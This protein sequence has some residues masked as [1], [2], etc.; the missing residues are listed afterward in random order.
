MDYAV[1]V[2]GTVGIEAATFGIP[3][4]TAGTGRYDRK[5]FTLDPQTPQAYLDQLAALETV[6]RLSEAQRELA[7]RFAYAVFVL[8]PLR[9]ESL[10]LR[11]RRDA[12]ASTEVQIKVSSPEEW[13]RAQDLSAFA[14]WLTGSSS[15][16]FM[17]PDPLAVSQPA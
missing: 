4:V 14:E 10:S 13:R 11:Y 16:D 7:Q 2:R 3:V 17:M 8:R 15:A 6:P 9:L 1:T 5:G 12:R